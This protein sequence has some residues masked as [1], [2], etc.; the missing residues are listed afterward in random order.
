MAD[1]KR[2][3]SPAE[4]ENNDATMT[5]DENETATSSSQK[6]TTEEVRQ[7]HTGDHVRYI[8]VFSSAG[9]L[10]ALFLLIWLYFGG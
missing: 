5:V 4:K 6:R 10:I 8:L 1:P 3:E 2:D 7:G 9:A